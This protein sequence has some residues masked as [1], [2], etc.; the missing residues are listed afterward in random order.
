MVE[1]NRDERIRG[2]VL[3]V[4]DSPQILG[5]L[6]EVLG[7]EHDVIIASSGSEA[8][9]LAHSEAPDLILL[10]VIMPEMDGYSVCA[11]LR[12]HA[13]T[14]DI[15]VLFITGQTDPQDE[16][17]G[18]ELGAIDYIHKPVN[19]PLVKIRVRNHME[20]KLNRDAL[21]GL[22]FT[23]GLT[24]VPNRRNF[25][26]ALEAEWQRS[27]RSHQ[28]LSMLMVDVDHFKLYND[29]L[30]HGS[31]DICLMN[32]AKALQAILQRSVDL[33]ARYGGE[34][35]ACLL[36]ETD[37]EGACRV[38]EQLKQQVLD[39][40]IPHPASPISP[41]VTV[42]I[43]V[44]TQVV[45]AGTPQALLIEASD[46]ALYCAK[47]QGRNR[48][49]VGGFEEPDSEPVLEV[50]DN[51]PRRPEPPFNE[52]GKTPY[53]LLV[54]DDTRMAMLLANRLETLGTKITR[55]HHAQAA[56]DAIAREAPDLILSDV[57]M[58]GM[59]GFE[60]CKTIKADPSRADIPFAMLTS[61][62]R[63]LRERSAVAGADDFLSKLEHET[64]FAMRT[65]SLLEI[66]M[67]RFLPGNVIDPELI[68]VISASHLIRMQM[69][70]HLTARQIQ[71]H[72]APDLSE[73]RELARRLRP[74]VLVVD[75][76]LGE[77]DSVAWIREM[78][79]EEWGA[80]ATVLLLAAKPEESLLPSFEDVADDR[81]AKP[82]EAAESRHRVG[83]M[84]R[85]AQ[86]RRASQEGPS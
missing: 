7:E 29:R 28:P 40:R 47:R 8:I 12:E 23:D 55:V 11:H 74:A 85:L 86:A 61:L 24:G 42:S 77:Q 10:D 21:K 58:P 43:G 59:D 33:F 45:E 36:P 64:V 39:L 1:P 71:V 54:E 18:L 69:G 35:F 51:A 65:R 79:R 48:V 46:R 63:N 9:E 73:G 32:V 52:Q 72:T 13:A 30:G 75:L 70:A 20:L 6:S 44:A 62:S 2:V 26:M 5:V 76:D 4:D 68:L 16:A 50:Q 38:A 17:R 80:V 57:V 3:I 41:H 25:D 67:R 15:P 84:L 19:P 22:S 66:G 81:L 53:I 31:G 78:Q 27:V 56:V 37:S 83:L 60:L 14:K 49:V 82:L 34:E